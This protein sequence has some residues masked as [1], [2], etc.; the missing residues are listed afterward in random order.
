MTA[1]LTVLA[2]LGIAILLSPET[3]ILGLI[4][5]CD[6]RAP[7]LVAWMYAIGAAV[8]LVMGVVIGLLV[9]P[10]PATA[11]KAASP[12]WTAFGVRA[13]IAAVLIVI[14]VQRV[15][16]ALRA[17]PIAAVEAQ[18]AN[19]PAPGHGA[20]SRLKAWFAA[21]FGG[22]IGKDLPAW[23]RCL[24]SGLLGFATMGIHPKCLAVAIAAGQ[25]AMQIGSEE[26]R[27]VGLT[28]FAAISMIPSVAP[29]IIETARA[30]ACAAIKESTERFMKTNGRWVSAAILLGAGAYV[31]VNAWHEMPGRAPA[32]AV[33]A[34]AGEAASGS[35]SSK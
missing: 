21:K 8:G 23:R 11:A 29:A 1:H 4:M 9:A 13:V 2:S 12:S 22:H 18:E 24:R 28:V 32:D 16:H 14:G 15:M 31:A 3:L 20:V 34:P 30:G 6:K 7:R 10:A 25:Q 27:L 26:D 17:A 5:A 33:T 35:A 19:V